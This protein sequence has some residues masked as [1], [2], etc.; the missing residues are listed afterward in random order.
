LGFF[1]ENYGENYELSGV[2]VETVRHG[3][4]LKEIGKYR[5]Q[6]A[7]IEKKILQFIGHI[8]VLQNVNIV[9]L[10][11]IPVI[12]RIQTTIMKPLKVVV[13]Y[14]FAK[15]NKIK[16]MISG[17][18]DRAES[19]KIQFKRKISAY[20]RVTVIEEKRTSKEIPTR[21]DRRKIL[22]IFNIPVMKNYH[23]TDIGILID[24][25]TNDLIEDIIEIVNTMKN[26]KINK[27]DKK[28]N[29][30]KFRPENTVNH[31]NT[32]T[33]KRIMEISETAEKELSKIGRKIAEELNN[34][35]PLRDIKLRYK[36]EVGS[37]IAIAVRESYLLG[38]S[39]IEQSQNRTVEFSNNL[40]LEMN[41]L[42]AEGIKDFWSSIEKLMFTN[43]NKELGIKFRKFTV[44]LDASDMH[45]D[46]FIQN[47]IQ[48]L[49]QVVTNT[50]TQASL[51]KSTVSAA[52]SINFS[53]PLRSEQ[54]MLIFVSERDSKVCPICLNLDGRTYNPGDPTMP[55]IPDDTHPNCRCRYLV[56]ETGEVFNA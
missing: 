4:P 36:Q 16:T 53:T 48:K 40:S 32:K 18:I 52:Q 56:Y 34:N 37:I 30:E 8:P 33:T 26:I 29:R 28:I 31:M 22:Q 49:I 7:P 44:K 1:G 50:I 35:I 20:N 42:I 54:I 3:L 13:P 55:E 23:K 14:T 17:F 5:I 10:P 12:Y 15:S 43:Q 11:E 45:Y 2:V 47:A 25:Y 39:Y 6:L 51:T 9:N 24:V 27:T 41:K 46:N 21:V 38:F 19:Y